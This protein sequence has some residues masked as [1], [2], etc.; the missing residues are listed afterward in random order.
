MVTPP[1]SYHTMTGLP[2]IVFFYKPFCIKAN[3]RATN[4]TTQRQLVTQDKMRLK[5]GLVNDKPVCLFT[6]FNMMS[7]FLPCKKAMKVE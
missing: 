7:V 6:F 4:Q 3:R 5:T 1:L 2:M